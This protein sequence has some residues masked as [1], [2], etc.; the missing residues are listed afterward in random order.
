[1]KLRKNIM[2]GRSMWETLKVLAHQEE[3]SVSELI[4]EAIRDLLAKRAQNP[5][6]Y[7][8]VTDRFS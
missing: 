7:D 5:V 6:K 4:R 2:I 1:M 8:P 3:S